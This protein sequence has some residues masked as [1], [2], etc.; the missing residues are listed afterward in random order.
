MADKKRLFFALWPDARTRDAVTQQTATVVTASGGRIVKPQNLHMTLAFLHSVETS[1]IP[2]IESAALRAAGNS[3]D[4]EL[5]QVGCWNR[6]RILWLAPSAEGQG[7]ETAGALAQSLWRE[8]EN[9]GFTPEQRRYRPHVTLARKAT[10]RQTAAP[11]ATI[12]W[13]ARRFALVE[14]ITGQRQSEY[15]V[16]KTFPLEPA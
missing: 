15:V 16:L 13:P 4:L 6:S 7:T 2:C 14:S 5:S 11:A 9:C 1:L 8:L 12:S 10:M 3:F